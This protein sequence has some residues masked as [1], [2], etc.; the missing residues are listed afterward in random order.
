MKTL[1][2]LAFKRWL[3][4]RSFPFLSPSNKSVALLLKYNNRVSGGGVD[5]YHAAF[6]DNAGLE[7]RIDLLEPGIFKYVSIL[8]GALLA[9]FAIAMAALIKVYS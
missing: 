6:P 5:E 7:S 4:Q 8:L 3:F 9:V 2:N 1:N